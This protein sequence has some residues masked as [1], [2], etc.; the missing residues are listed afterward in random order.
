[1][2]NYVILVTQKLKVG[3]SNFLVRA[4][5]MICAN[6]HN[7]GN[8]CEV[9]LD[10][11]Q[12]VHQKYLAMKKLFLFAFSVLFTGM[13]INAQDQ[14]PDRTRKQD[15]IHQEDHLQLMD[16]KLYRYQQGIS[17]EVK[18]QIRLQNGIVVYPDGS[19]Q[20]Q[21]QDRYQLRK[22]ECLAMDGSRY[23]NQKQ[24]NRRNMMTER[25]IE[26]IRNKNIDRNRMGNPGNQGG[27]GRR[28]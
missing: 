4:F 21:N 3:F 13:A 16:G 17:N 26:R 7:Q 11:T 10:H 20:L 5:K 27:N 19:Y 14:D 23:R 18:E 8:N 2:G 12:I 9:P 15:R 25:Q 22:G 6:H 24:F 1:M 28:G